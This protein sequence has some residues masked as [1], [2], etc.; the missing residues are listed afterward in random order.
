MLK[1]VCFTLFISFF[2]IVKAE[3]TT[4]S[5]KVKKI[6]RYIRPSIYYNGFTTPEKDLGD[7]L[8]GAYRFKQRN[9]GFYTPLV[10]KTWI[11]EDSIKLNTFHL[12]LTGNIQSSRPYFSNINYEHRIYKITL[13]MRAIYSQGKNIWF[14]HFSP[15]I[16][17]DDKTLDDPTYRFAGGFLFNRTVSNNFSYRLGVERT[18]TFGRKLYL[19]VIGF[20]FGQLDKFNV[21]ILLPRN[22]S[23]NFP[24]G[25]KCY[26][27]V[28]ARPNGGIYTI[29]NNDS[30]YASFGNK[31][32]F[33]RKDITTGAQFNVR[34]GNSFSFFIA[35]G[36]TH[37]RKIYFLDR[38][39]PDGSNKADISIDVNPGIFVNLGFTIQLGKSKR[40]YNDHV[41]YDVFNINNIYGQ[42]SNAT[43][44]LDIPVD[45]K[46]YKTE[47]INKIKY[48]DIED[49]IVDE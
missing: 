35:T 29:S 48:K 9:I 8:F 46:K 18:Y 20:R 17:Q 23:F 27:N 25:K 41:L 40:V 2:G 30:L 37:K 43:Q 19:P 11:D 26:M 38:T 34:A 45:P 7:S 1:L 33:A 31:I 15:F 32:T 10:T 13:G 12:L 21:S 5:I 49:L 22:V 36:F 47:Q 39:E 16:A 3:I 44:N 42:G 24:I 14:F 4:D 6:K 28:Y